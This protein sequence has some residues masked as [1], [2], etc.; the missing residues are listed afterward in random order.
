MERP[1]LDV[2]SAP[3]GL[4]WAV[5]AMYLILWSVALL[6]T[7]PA[8]VGQRVLPPA[9]HYVAA[10]ALHICAYA[11]LAILTG[12]LRAPARY[13]WLLLLLL[14]LHGAG[15]EFGQLFVPRRHASFADIGF[16]HIGLFWGLILSWPWWAD[17]RSGPHSASYLSPPVS[18]DLS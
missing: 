9:W 8:D 16:D 1:R 3:I 18:S 2:P 7:Y 14:S 11:G 13:R 12:W 4:R 17:R 5:W 15:T 6:T 10:K